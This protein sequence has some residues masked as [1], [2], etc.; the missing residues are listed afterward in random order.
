MH[1]QTQVRHLAPAGF[2]QHTYEHT[3]PISLP[4]QTVWA[5]LNDPDTFVKGQVFPFRV[6]FVEH[7]GHNN[8][9][10]FSPGVQNTHHG[11]CLNCAGEITAIQPPNPQDPATPAYRDLQYYY[12]S[13][14][15]SPRLIRPTRLEFWLAPAPADTPNTPDSSL[16]TVRV[17][18]FC[19]PA[20]A[21]AW[22]RLQH[23]FWA[24]FF[25]WTARAAAK[26]HTKPTTQSA[27]NNQ[28]AR[29]HS[30]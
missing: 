1:D 8:S 3:L 30:Q 18:S 29:N 9:S 16:L 11:P 4:I 19:K 14:I 17:S 10:G 7:S 13:F 25:K 26:R 27:S 2:A 21:K 5:W 20:L 22:T 24:R 23:L 12:G 15:L 28:S 6:E